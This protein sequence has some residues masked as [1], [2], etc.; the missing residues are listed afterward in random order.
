MSS[1][2]LENINQIQQYEDND[3]DNPPQ[4]P[5][6]IPRRQRRRLCGTGSHR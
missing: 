6:I 5:H 2:M 1:Q 3:D 4:A